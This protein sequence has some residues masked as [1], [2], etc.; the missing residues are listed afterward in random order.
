MDSFKYNL[1]IYT[2]KIISGRF[3]VVCD[4]SLVHAVFRDDK[5]FAFMPHAESATETL[6]FLSEDA[7]KIVRA[8]DE[9]EGNYGP[10]SFLLDFHK[11]QYEYLAPGSPL[12]ELNASILNT[13]GSYSMK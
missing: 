10:S 5:S 8:K 9:P 1:P 4:P 11:V 6:A 7:K 12:V 2:L 3:Y 13:V